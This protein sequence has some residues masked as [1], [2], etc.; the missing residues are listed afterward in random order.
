[1]ESID[2]LIPAS[3]KGYVITKNLEV[4]KEI[5]KGAYGKIVEGKWEGL[6][7]AIKVLHPILYQ[8]ANEQETITQVKKFLAECERL[9][10]LRHLN[11]VQFFGICIFA[12]SIM[13]GLVMERLTC[14]L[15]D[16][17]NQNI[18]ISHKT[19][20]FILYQIALGL[21]YL[22]THTPTIIHCDLS[23]KNIAISKG[24]EAKIVDFGIARLFFPNITMTRQFGTL[25]FLAPE[26]LGNSK[27]TEKIDIFS[28]GCVT[29]QTY[30]Q[31]WPE[32]IGQQVFMD[33]VTNQCIFNTEID[34]R[35]KYIKILQ[36]NIAIRNETLDLI[37]CCLHN[38][39]QSRP[40]S[41]ELADHFEKI[42]APM[43]KV[44]PTEICEAAHPHLKNY[45]EELDK[46]TIGSIKQWTGIKPKWRHQTKLPEK[47]WVTSVAELNKKVYIS[48]R[49]GEF[50]RYNPF[51]YDLNKD[52]WDQLP[53]LPSDIHQFSLVAV[54]KINRILAIGGENINVISK[55]VFTW[56]E[57][58]WSNEYT[59]MPTARSRPSSICYDTSVIVAGGIIKNP[60]IFTQAVEI[61]YINGSYSRWDIV[62]QLPFGVYGAIPL[63]VENT[64]YIAV[65]YDDQT[66]VNNI[67]YDSTRNI[68]KANIPDL[69]KSS[70]ENKVNKS[71]WKK[72]PDMPYSS[73]SINYYK[74]N[75]IAFTGD[76]FVQLSEKDVVLCQTVPLIHIYNPRTFSWDCVDDL[77]GTIDFYLGS[78]IHINESTILFMGGISGRHEVTEDLVTDCY[79]LT[80][81]L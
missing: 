21:R 35:E 16:L 58:T 8:Q 36:N 32:P 65:G 31:Q 52:K 17:L 3:L 1:M 50:S 29:L 14:S 69:L 28:F 23:S 20:S 75:L 73:W 37:K 49:T 61:L 74:N 5:A 30:T 33:P 44:I 46:A 64:I 71:I 38:N 12:G 11:I 26:I 70:N 80:F 48:V 13:P 78:S 72:L 42:A 62:E 43:L 53:P 66:L 76:S 15:N 56:N 59:D 27:Y 9:S 81:G 18:V 67:R 19:K 41:A 7:V 47:F 6:S 39:E 79:A 54:H 45:H 40:T 25:D 51:V 68:V 2:K 24:M 60:D 77:S 55:K 10:M 34:R 57:N 63:I 4:G 22:H